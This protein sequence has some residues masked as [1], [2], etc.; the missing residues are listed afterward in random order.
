MPKLQLAPIRL[1]PLLQKPQGRKL[2][3]LGLLPHNQMQHDRHRNQ[4][5]TAEQR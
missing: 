3:P 1:L 5:S 2:Q 4:C